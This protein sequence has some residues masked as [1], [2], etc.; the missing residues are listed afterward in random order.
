MNQSPY[1][2]KAT[3]KRVVDGDTIVVDIDLGFHV[4]IKDHPLRMARI[5]APEKKGE[6][7]AAGTKSMNVLK[8]KLEGKEIVIRTYR[9]G[10]DKYGRLLADV[11]L[12]DECVNDWL[13]K[14]GHAIPFMV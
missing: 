2:Y 14:E 7:F 12:N 9:S 4:T 10:E 1:T 3:V 8:Q 5:N 11:F 13:L 6:T